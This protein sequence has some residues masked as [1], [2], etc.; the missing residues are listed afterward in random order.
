[1]ERN[2]KNVPNH[3]NRSRTFQ[4]FFN[5]TQLLTGGI[6]AL[7]RGLGAFKGQEIDENIVDA[8]RNLLFGGTN[9]SPIDLGVFNILRNYDHGVP[10]LNE[11]R[12]E[13]GL[14]PLMS[15]S[16]LTSD[17]T[18]QAQFASVYTNINE[19]ELWVGV[20]PSVV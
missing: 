16:D 12:V 1:M 10:T 7:V 15:F 4:A 14:A 17:M 5:P 20:L 2:K 8:V 18:L 6:D 13:Y 11:V 9:S 19:V 3:H